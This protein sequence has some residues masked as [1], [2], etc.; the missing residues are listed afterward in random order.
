M[1][2]KHLLIPLAALCAA[3]CGPRHSIE[4]SFEGFTNDTVIL[5]ARPL[6]QYVDF[7]AEPDIRTDTEG[8][9]VPLSSLR[10]KWIEAIGKHEL[11]WINLLDTREGR[12]AEII[13]NVYGIGPTP[14]RSSSTPKGASSTFSSANAPDSPKNSKRR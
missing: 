10:E 6:A 3:A 5:Q 4:A 12:P 14:R 2:P 1:N 7:T 11:P 8:R 9:L 13:D